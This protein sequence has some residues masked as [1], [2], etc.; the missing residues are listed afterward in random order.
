ML[1]A[2]DFLFFF[3]A[4]GVTPP[5]TFVFVTNEKLDGITPQGPIPF[6]APISN[7]AQFPCQPVGEASSLIYQGSLVD[8]LGDAITLD[9]ITTLELTVAV[10]GSHGNTIVNNVDHVDILNNNQGRVDANGNF[11]ITLTP[12]DTIFTN[13]SNV[14]EQRSMIVEYTYGSGKLGRHE[15]IFEIVS[16]SAPLP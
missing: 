1:Y 16:I 13:P 6:G 8:I 7:L 12:N 5:P 3:Q 14:S 15:A 10:T 4:D 2:S 11:T 9:Q